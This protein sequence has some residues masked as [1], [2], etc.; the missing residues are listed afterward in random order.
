MAQ[1]PLSEA[2]PLLMELKDVTMEIQ[3]QET[4]A[5]LTDLLKVAFHVITPICLLIV[6]PA[7]M[8][9]WLIDHHLLIE[10][11]VTM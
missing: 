11:T 3:W 2:I 9:F 6:I 5:L 8:V 4:A 7:E 10:T 1:L